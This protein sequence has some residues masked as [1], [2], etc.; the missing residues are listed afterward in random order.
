MTSQRVRERLGWSVT[1]LCNSCAPDGGAGARIT[2]CLEEGGMNNKR[3]GGRL[4]GDVWRE[5]W[6]NFAQLCVY[7]WHTE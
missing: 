5:W 3:V 4:W 6:D 1:Q 2:M 7:A